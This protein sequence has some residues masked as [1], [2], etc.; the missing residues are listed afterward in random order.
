MGRRRQFALVLLCA[1]VTS[2]GW[3]AARLGGFERPGIESIA[4]A[5]R[6]RAAARAATISRT[7]GPVAIAA[8]ARVTTSYGKLA[9]PADPSPRETTFGLASVSTA[10]AAADEEGLP[11]ET[12]GRLVSLFRPEAPVE[13]Q[14]QPAVRP[15]E[16][17]DECLVID[18]CIDEYLWALY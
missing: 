9:E 5:I 4:T 6:D 11:P 2:A 7:D 12:H 16:I 18:T 13:E 14:V 1:T 15:I 10:E 3:C 17:V 8:V